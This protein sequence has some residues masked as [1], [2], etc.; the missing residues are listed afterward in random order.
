MNVLT[1]INWRL[2]SCGPHHTDLGAGF[3]WGCAADP[4]QHSRVQTVD[5]ET[6]QSMQNRWGQ[7]RVVSSTGTSR[8]EHPGPV[9]RR[10]FD[11][12]PVGG[13]GQ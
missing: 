7:V 12:T 8:E 10:L 3:L 6:L 13:W 1:T 9:G 4:K 11:C 5:G 2:R